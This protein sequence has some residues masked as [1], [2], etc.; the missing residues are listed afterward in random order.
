MRGGSTL[1]AAEGAVQLQGQPWRATVLIPP[2]QLGPSHPLSSRLA[3]QPWLRAK[4][5]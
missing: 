3:T 4:L 1:V 2:A 5:K